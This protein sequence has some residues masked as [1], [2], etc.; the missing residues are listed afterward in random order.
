MKEFFL[1]LLFSEW[2]QLTPVPVDVVNK[3]VLHPSEPISAITSGAALHVDLEV[4]L[5]GVGIDE[6]GIAQSRQIFDERIPPGSVYGLLI[7]EDGEEVLLDEAF[8]SLQN[9]KPW[10]VL[11]PNSGMPTGIEFE[12]VVIQSDVVL[13]EIVVFWKNYSM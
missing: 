7:G 9:D 3:L 13:K 2:V 11:R 5:S 4:F 1:I 6:T 10:L 8:L 12:E